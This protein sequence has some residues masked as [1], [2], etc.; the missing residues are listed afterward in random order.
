MKMTFAANHS[1]FAGRDG[2]NLTARKIG[3]RLF[4]ETQK[5]VSLRFSQVGSSESFVVTGRGELHLSVLIETLRREGFR[6]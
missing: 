3:D 5:D 4:R 2:K 1:P 6:L